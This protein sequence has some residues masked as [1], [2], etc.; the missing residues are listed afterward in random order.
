MLHC[1]GMGRRHGRLDVERTT[2][3]NAG[4]GKPHRCVAKCNPALNISPSIACKTQ[5]H[6]WQPVVW[7]GPCSCVIPLRAVTCLRCS[8]LTSLSIHQLTHHQCVSFRGADPVFLCWRFLLPSLNRGRE[9]ALFAV[10]G[11]DLSCLLQ[12]ALRSPILGTGNLQKCSPGQ[13]AVTT[14][15]MHRCKNTGLEELM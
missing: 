8:T 2:W 3:R 7:Y 1:R 5:G 9:D 11:K 10:L 13:G 12:F 4:R 15:D 14:S 6:W